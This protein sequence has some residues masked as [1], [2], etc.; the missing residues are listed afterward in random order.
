MYLFIY[1]LRGI[2]HA[3]YICVPYACSVCRGPK[4]VLE[5]QNWSYKWLYAF[6]WA[7]GIESGSPVSAACAV[8]G[9]F[10]GPP[11]TSY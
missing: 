8:D 3:L 11:L 4:R 10:F 9:L 6:L 7:V 1:M 2:S 5:L